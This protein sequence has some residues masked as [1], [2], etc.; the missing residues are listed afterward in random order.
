[1]REQDIACLENQADV[2]DEY[3]EDE[4]DEGEE[5]LCPADSYFL[6]SLRTFGNDDGDD[7]EEEVLCPGSTFPVLHA[8]H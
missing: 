2:E 1:V 4:H 7:D 3:D 6:W 8:M 5:V